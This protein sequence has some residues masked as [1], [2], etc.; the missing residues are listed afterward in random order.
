MK[1]ARKYEQKIKTLLKSL[2]KEGAED[3]VK[4]DPVRALVEAI[5]GANAARKQASKTLAEFEREYVDFNELRVSQLKEIVERLEK[6]Y[7]DAPARAETILAALGGLFGRANATTL[8]FIKDMPKREMRRFLQELG[9]DEYASACVMLFGCGRHAVAVDE[10]LVESLAMGG[11]AHPGS[12]PADVRGFLERVISQKD[13]IRA[14]NFFRL[15]VEQ[16]A[17]ALAKKRKAE[18]Q[19]RAAAEAEAEAKAKAQAKAAR[20][21]R[22]AA[23]KRQKATKA[24]K[25]KASKV[26]KKPKA[27]PTAA[28]AGKKRAKVSPKPRPGHEEPLG[29]K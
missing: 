2:P 28:G 15:F 12:D 19:A 25:A 27:S 1:H 8:D 3:L 4:A 6:S 10:D 24:K 11:Y 21:K 29:K 17:R 18:A 22:S 5:L 7:T 26:R 13:A 9:L 14:H 23:A 16:N 20:R